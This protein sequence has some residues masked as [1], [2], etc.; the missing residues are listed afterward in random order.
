M[1]GTE[2]AR[3]GGK[4][5]F[6]GHGVLLES[7]AGGDV[8]GRYGG[9]FSGDATGASARGALAQEAGSSSKDFACSCKCDSAGS[10]IRDTSSEGFVG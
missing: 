1:G 6:E 5:L 10:S 2:R 4:N 7:V 8:S 9:G 3:G